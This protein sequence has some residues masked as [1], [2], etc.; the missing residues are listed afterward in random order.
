M[1][2]FRKIASVIFLLLLGFTLK[3]GLVA[4]F[5]LQSLQKWHGG[6]LK[7][8]KLVRLATMEPPV[9]TEKVLPKSS[10]VGTGTF[11]A[12]RSLLQRLNGL[13]ALLP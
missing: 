8:G 4:S 5:Q 7:P 11:F 13:L 6:L 10:G 12:L 3:A 2:A 1:E 9:V